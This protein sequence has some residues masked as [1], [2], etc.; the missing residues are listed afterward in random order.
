[1]AINVLY[2]MCTNRTVNGL[3]WVSYPL[4]FCIIQLLSL[5][6]GKINNFP[7]IFLLSQ[8]NK[9]NTKM[10]K[11]LYKISYFIEDNNFLK[12]R[13]VKFLNF[14]LRSHHKTDLLLLKKI[15]R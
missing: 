4:F 7:G 2:L 13:L 8:D 15:I 10:L 12:T 6:S 9:T 11:G 14:D 3:I 1:M 5:Q